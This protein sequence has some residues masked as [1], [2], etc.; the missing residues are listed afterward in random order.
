MA[1]AKFQG[2]ARGKGFSN[3]DPGYAAL[4]RLQEK[5]NQD[6]A[7][8]K[9]E[10][11]DQRNRDLQAEADLERVM[12][13]EEA[14]RKGIY[15]EDKVL[16]TR[17]NALV[18]NRN[19]EVSNFNARQKEHEQQLKNIE[20]IVAFSKSAFESFQTIQKK[21]WD[22]T[23][24]ESYNYYMTHGMTLED[25]I[26]L[27]LLE[28]KQ[29]AQGEQLEQEADR[30][31][32]EGYTSQEVNWVRGQNSASDYGRLKAYSVIAGNQFGKWAEQKLTQ[33]GARTTCL[34][35]TSPSPRDRTRSRMPS[36]A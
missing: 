29:W 26:Q 14:N 6:L 32:A 24:D 15:I 1:K 34:L 28:E 4:T 5:Q 10:Q 8:L 36:S 3:I 27:D 31:R 20:S 13:A 35:Y 25:Q 9:Q 18:S 17:E 30:L 7:N 16:S 11:K 22:A 12:A 21:N 19:Q 33:M 2:Y 23:S